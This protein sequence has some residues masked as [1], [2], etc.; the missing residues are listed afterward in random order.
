MVLLVIRPL[1]VVADVIGEIVFVD[2]DVRIHRNNRT[3]K[4]PDFGDVIENMDQVETGP[5]SVLEVAIY[6]ETGISASIVVQELSVMYFDISSLQREQ[7]GALELVTG[8]LDLKVGRLSGRNQ[9][10]VRTSLASMGVRGT[11]FSVTA[12]LAGEI[13][14]ATF[15]GKVECQ[16]SDGH[17]LFAI[18]GEFAE[19]TK[20]ND[21]R[22]VPVST[23]SMRRFRDNW[24]AERSRALEANAPRAIAS[25]ARR[26]IQL[27]EDFIQAYVRLVNNRGVIQKWIE[28]DRLGRVGSSTERIREKRQIISALI[29]IRRNL[30]I[31]ERIYYRLD[32][33]IRQF[34]D[35]PGDTSIAP[36]LTLRRFYRQFQ[37]DKDV[38]GMRM[39]EIRYII[40]LYALRNDGETPFADLSGSLEGQG[41][42]GDRDAFMNSGF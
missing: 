33:L 26:H 13:L 30:V 18:P 12:N 41:F 2:G 35:L 20:D 14:L 37:E 22:N 28:E 34:S 6:P 15:E 5:G 38:L 17:V 19:R 36:G 42:L 9:L 40:K 39:Q 32:Q 25:Y 1:A 4:Q 21:W 29:H 16:T 11:E 23:G 10:D 31:F 8:Q 24:I 7:S 27:K 3:V